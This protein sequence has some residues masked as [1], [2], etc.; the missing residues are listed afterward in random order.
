MVGTE[1][2]FQNMGSDTKLRAK[3]VQHNNSGAFGLVI[4]KRVL[5]GRVNGKE[6]G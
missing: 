1:V 2:L 4:P 6:M 5:S 3:R